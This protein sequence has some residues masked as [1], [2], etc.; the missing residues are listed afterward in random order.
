MLLFLFNPIW[1]LLGHKTWFWPILLLNLSECPLKGI[2]SEQ[3]HTGLS[4]SVPQKK[5]HRKKRVRFRGGELER[6]RLTSCIYKE[7]TTSAENSKISAPWHLWHIYPFSQKTHCGFWKDEGTF[8]KVIEKASKEKFS[9][10]TGKGGI[11]HM[12]IWMNCHHTS[13]R[14]LLYFRLHLILGFSPS[15]L[16]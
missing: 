11:S 10:M 12:L 2:C 8:I 15:N 6:G 3:V 16:N 4:R 13:S 14:K 5:Q 9:L 7:Y 1:V